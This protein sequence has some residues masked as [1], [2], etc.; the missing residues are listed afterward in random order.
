MAKYKDI[1]F[2]F[3]PNPFT[4]DLNLVQDS[5]SIKQSLKNILL[6]LKGEKS[7]NYSFGGAVQNVL[8]EYAGETTLSI[9]GDIDSAIRVNEPR[10]NLIS[11]SI[12]TSGT[13]NK[14]IIDYEY[15]LETGQ[16]VTETTTVTTS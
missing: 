16:T 3:M 5:T 8:F 15:V 7:F 2:N 10:V 13:E 14:S 6:T 11:V 1:D 12:D 4:G 9:L